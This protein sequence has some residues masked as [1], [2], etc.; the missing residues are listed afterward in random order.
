MVND[1]RRLAMMCDPLPPVEL[2]PDPDDDYLLATAQVASVHY[3]VT[4]DKSDLL[5]L[6]NHETTRIITAWNMVTLLDK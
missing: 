6:R 4:G 3:L 2:S 1:I 5:A